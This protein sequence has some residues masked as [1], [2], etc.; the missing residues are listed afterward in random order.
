M[1]SRA[2]HD[3][4]LPT[5]LREN[6][7]FV[8][9]DVNRCFYKIVNTKQ[10]IAIEVFERFLTLPQLRIRSDHIESALTHRS[11]PIISAL[12]KKCTRQVLDRALLWMQDTDCLARIFVFF[13][14]FFS[15]D[16]LRWRGQPFPQDCLPLHLRIW[17]PVLSE[18]SCETSQM[19]DLRTCFLLSVVKVAW[20]T[21]TDFLQQIRDQGTSFR[22]V[23]CGCIVHMSTAERQWLEARTLLPP[24][25]L[26]QQMEQLTPD[27]DLLK[28]T[29]QLRGPSEVLRGSLILFRLTHARATPIVI[30][31]LLERD[32]GT[33][34][35]IPAFFEASLPVARMLLTFAHPFFK[36]KQK[37]RAMKIC[38]KNHW[39]TLLWS[40]HWRTTQGQREMLYLISQHVVSF[41][42]FCEVGRFACC[43]RN[44]DVPLTW[45]TK[46]LHIHLIRG[47]SLAHDIACL[48]NV[49]FKSMCI[50]LTGRGHP[51]AA[52][53]L[54]VPGMRM[55]CTGGIVPEML[56]DEPLR[57]LK[58]N[59]E[60]KAAAYVSYFLRKPQLTI[61]LWRSKPY[62][63]PPYDLLLLQRFLEKEVWSRET[64]VLQACCAW[65]LQQ[66][67]HLLSFRDIEHPA[68][69]A[70]CCVAFWRE[71]NYEASILCGEKKM[72]ED[73][74]IG[75]TYRYRAR[76]HLAKA[77]EQQARRLLQAYGSVVLHYGKVNQQL[78][79]A[80]LEAVC[81]HSETAKTLFRS[82]PSLPPEDYVFDWQDTV[83]LVLSLLT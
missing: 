81:G 23:N 51:Q 25:L 15:E 30:Q 5:V 56:F 19:C 65:G 39:H 47:V 52:T 46:L 6:Q 67:Q 22:C 78:E 33:D 54:D 27:S 1:L 18:R 77:E 72:V 31:W 80:L 37:V 21:T 17:Q 48:E 59:N 8:E 61:E 11:F 60:T 55:I 4:T 10:P 74:K 12:F 70:F 28:L 62:K 34:Y 20:L 44:A 29:Q 69:Q 7:S 13:G 73:H 64:R 50:G 49:S 63:I 35:V 16:N 26:L 58:A 3:G 2:F 9:V 42:S 79:Y 14:H 57:H 71:Q 41:L 38:Q 43:A 53:I 66:W 83:N 75:F 24:A 32:I 40:F 36:P 82:L 45:K 76:S 68:V